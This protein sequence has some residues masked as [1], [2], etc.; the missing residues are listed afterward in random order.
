[1]RTSILACALA[2][3]LAF[4]PACGRPFNV[5]TAPGFIELEGQHVEGYDYRATSPEFWR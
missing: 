2:A 1:M 3:A 4:V 5:Q